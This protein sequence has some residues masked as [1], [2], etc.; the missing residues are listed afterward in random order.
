MGLQWLEKHKFLL[1][2]IEISFWDSLV[3]FTGTMCVRFASGVLWI[4]PSTPLPP[5]ETGSFTCTHI[6][7]TKVS[8]ISLLRCLKRR[9]LPNVN[10]LYQKKI[11]TKQREFFFFSLFFLH[12]SASFL[13][14]YMLHIVACFNFALRAGRCGKCE[15]ICK[16][17]IF[18]PR[19]LLK[20]AK[21]VNLKRYEETGC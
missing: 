16:K 20:T 15:K 7:H 6:F 1:K 10:A 2:T 17:K 9:N 5:S 14:I 13:I 12:F 19:K 3:R 21:K 8:R 4:C 11:Y 18:L